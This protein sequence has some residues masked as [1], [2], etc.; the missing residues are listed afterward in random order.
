MSQLILRLLGMP[1][2]ELEGSPIGVDRRKAI[3][4]LVYLVLTHGAQGRDGL[5][6]LLWPGYDQV[7]ARGNLRRALSLLH[8]ALRQEWLEVDRESVAFKRDDDLWLDVA[9]FRQ[10]LAE[11]RSHG[12]PANT[13]C[14]R[15]IAPLT[16]A[17]SLYRDD[18]LT[19]FTLPDAPDF[20]EWQ[21]FETESLRHELSGALE[22]LAACYAAQR[23]FG[24]AIAHARRRVAL[25]PLH[26]PAQRQLMQ[27][28]SWAGNRAGAQRQYQAIVDLLRREVGATP[29]PE[30]VA[31]AQAIS[32]NRLPPPAPLSIAPPPLPAFWDAQS[33]SLRARTSD[34]AASREAGGPTGEIRVVTVLCAGIARVAGSTG[35]VKLETLATGLDLLWKALKTIILPDRT[36]IEQLMGDSVVAVFG[37]TQAREDDPAEAIS[38][39]LA[40]SEAARNQGQPI[41]AGIVTGE[42][43]LGSVGSTDCTPVSVLGPLIRT[44]ARLQNRARPDQ[45][46]TDSTTYRLTRQAYRYR[47]TGARDEAEPAGVYVVEASRGSSDTALAGRSP[48]RPR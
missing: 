28:Y 4:L 7:T 47:L 34:T 30:T 41:S 40:L 18:F 15:C 21:R 45:L 39:A 32:E 31:L 8:N 25:D 3:A 44:A 43:Y 9:E 17:A 2:I 11:C 23:E 14:D 38:V 12:H 29:E 6:T 37:A 22:L 24:A 33:Q 42:A 46:L 10:L 20:D 48:A 1:H 27:V 5:A 19:G 16:L 13:A 35:G 26:E 36:Q